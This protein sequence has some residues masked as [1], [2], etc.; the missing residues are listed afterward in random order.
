[1][2]CF[3]GLCL[4]YFVRFEYFVRGIFRSALTSVWAAEKTGSHLVQNVVPA[5]TVSCLPN[6]A[7]LGELHDSYKCL[8][9]FPDVCMRFV[10]S[11]FFFHAVTSHSSTSCFLFGSS[12]FLWGTHCSSILFSLGVL[13]CNCMIVLSGDL[14]VG[15][16]NYELMQKTLVPRWLG[17]SAILSVRMSQLSKVKVEH[18]S[19][20]PM[21]PCYL[22]IIWRSGGE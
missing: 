16:L 19:W 7:T 8:F 3:F 4:Q 12:H 6:K 2:V 17:L 14:T 5:V 11:V 10:F 18:T 20:V 13:V 9:R 15:F 1:M 22:M 21:F